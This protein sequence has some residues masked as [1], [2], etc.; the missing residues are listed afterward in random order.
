MTKY[1]DEYYN[2]NIISS[3]LNRIRKIVE[4]MDR[5]HVKIMEVCGTHTMNIGRSGLR[6][7]LPENLTLLSGPGCPVCV[8]PDEYITRSV[9]L[10]GMK[11]VLVTT[12]GD[13]LK[14]PDG[15]GR[16]LSQF[17]SGKVVTVYSPLDA[18]E[19]AGRTDREVVFLGV[20]FETTSPAVARVIKK[21]E[22]EDISNFSVLSSHKVIPP[23]LKVLA[24]SPDNRIDGFLLPGHVSVTIGREGYKGLSIRGVITG[25]EPADI[26]AGIII[27]LENMT[28]SDEFVKNSYTRAV[29]E[30]GNKNMQ[31]IL[32]EVFEIKNS[33]WRGLGEIPKS[34]YEIRDSF[35]KYD[36]A[37][38]FDITI[39]S[40][41]KKTEC[42]CGEILKGLKTP[43]DC[44]LFD[45]RCNP[46]NPVGPCMV[47]SE[48]ACSA[49]YRYE[50]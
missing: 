35:I 19:L 9:K 7:R 6:E 8:T 43:F 40:K 44:K 26:L 5:D 2:K 33:K 23:A 29:T 34:G 10:A 49:Y 25:F 14:V 31:K 32:K 13:M 36:A 46:E 4:D 22:A 45:G 1:K 38:K 37:E 42:I 3:Q 50:R 16:S 28:G 12:F 41:E 21:A 15:R 30:E 17:S 39:S 20:G 24:E 48:G 47:S 18:L 27:L 11:D